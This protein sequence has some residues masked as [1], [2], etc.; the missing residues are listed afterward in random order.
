M[1]HKYTIHFTKTIID[2]NPR[3]QSWKEVNSNVLVDAII[4]F[5]NNNGIDFKEI[6]MRHVTSNLIVKCTKEK[7]KMLVLELIKERYG[8]ELEN[9]KL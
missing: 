7:Y 2:Y 5:C 1:K 4:R 9:I 3:N 6:K 8:I